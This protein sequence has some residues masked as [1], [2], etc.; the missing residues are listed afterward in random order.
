MAALERRMR[1]LSLLESSPRRP[2]LPDSNKTAASFA[3]GF[4]IEDDHIPFMRRGVNVLHLMP[5]MYPRVWHTIDDDAQHLD[6]K[7]CRDWSRLVTAFAM[8]WLGLGQDVS[9]SEH[10]T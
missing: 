1:G 10:K 4:H 8:E 5:N 2:F 3:R 6:L 7:T 9:T